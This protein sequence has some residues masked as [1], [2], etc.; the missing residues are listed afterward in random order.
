MVS[1]VFNTNNFIY[2]WSFVY[3]KFN[4]FRYYYVSLTIQLS[5][6]HFFTNDQTVLLQAI[7]SSI[8]YLFALNLHVKQFC[9]THKLDSF[10]CHHSQAE[11]TRE[12]RQWRSTLRSPKLQHYWSL[13][14]FNVIQDT[15]RVDW[16]GRSYLF[17]EMQF[18]YSTTSADW[19]NCVRNWNLTIL[20]NGICIKQNW[21]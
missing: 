7:Q 8:S 4:V 11:W 14:L 19:V 17:A 18:V 6:N 3:T 13:R 16:V 15:H 5:I 21:S 20:P 9:L 1:L 12:R 10:R 2:Y